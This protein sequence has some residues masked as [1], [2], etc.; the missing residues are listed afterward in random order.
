[1]FENEDARA[2]KRLKFNRQ[3]VEGEAGVRPWKT[4]AEGEEAVV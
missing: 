2:H 4:G 3:L 1:M